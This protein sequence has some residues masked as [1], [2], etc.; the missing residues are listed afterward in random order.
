MNRGD[1]FLENSGVAFCDF[2]IDGIN[3]VVVDQESI[4]H[5]LESMGAVSIGESPSGFDGIFHLALQFEGDGAI[6]IHPEEI[7]ILKPELEVRIG[8]WYSCNGYGPDRF[9]AIAQEVLLPVVGRDIFMANANYISRSSAPAP[10]N[11]NDFSLYIGYGKKSGKSLHSGGEKVFGQH[12]GNYVL[13]SPEG[14]GCIISDPETGLEIIQIEGN[15]VWILFCCAY[16]GNRSESDE[17]RV[18]RRICEE[19]AIELALSSEEK[20]ERRR[21]QTEA[22]RAKSREGYVKEC[23]KRFA[24]TV[25][26]TKKAITDGETRIGQLQAELTK[27]I[28]EVAGSKRKL[29]Q[30]NASMGGELEK[31]GREFDKL[32]AVPK[33]LDVQVADG[34]VKV[35]T[36]TL[37][38]IDPRTKLTHEIGKFRI[39]IYENCVNGGVLWFNLTR[40]VSAYKSNMHAPH[41][42]HR[43]NACYGSTAEIWPELI[44]AYEFAAAAMVAIQFVESVNVDDGAGKYIDRWPIADISKEE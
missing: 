24:K 21:Q 16:Y 33:V 31:Y 3:G 19:L 17:H 32:L 40:Q 29:E 27:K 43:G 4:G 7:E 20:S 22:K 26:G 13:I 8:S 41:V 42:F 44:G 36:D 39:E 23:S 37:Y 35:F 34:V 28:R 25:E 6:Q 38:C 11:P 30:L 1:D 5:A 15:R 10:N 12:L 18:F 2:K 9:V 14:N